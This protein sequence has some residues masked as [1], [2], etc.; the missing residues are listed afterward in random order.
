MKP[1]A[2]S[3]LLVAMLLGTT[4]VIAQQAIL[5]GQYGMMAGSMA[6]P[7]FYAG[8]FAGYYTTDELKTADGIGVSGPALNSW[9]FGPFVSYVSKFKILGGNYNA[10]FAVPFATIKTDYPRLGEGLSTGVA[11]TQLWIIP[12]SLGWHLKQAD[13]TTHWA[14]YPPTG[15]YSPGADDNTALGMW[16][17]EFSVRGTYFFDTGRNWHAS[18]SLF[19]DINGKKEDTDWKTGNPFTVMYGAGR[20]FG[21]GKL[22]GWIGV[23][24]YAQW[25]VTSTS[26][27]DVPAFVTANKSQI[28]GIGPELTTLQG[29]FTVRA[30]W[31]FSGRF[32]TQGFNLYT[33]FA[34]PI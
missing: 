5:K 30:I 2:M 22:F 24:G 25:Q 10:I 19:Y 14:I 15:R 7:G 11:L 16:V 32:S 29:A 8:A 27:S 1:R 34:L 6:P 18:V 4:P 26:G 20:N 9:V 13:I 17:N 31:E 23:A 12:F 3:L 28:Y 33:Q 21:K